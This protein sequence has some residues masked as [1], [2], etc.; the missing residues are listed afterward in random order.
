MRVTLFT[1]YICLVFQFCCYVAFAKSLLNVVILSQ[2]IPL[3]EKPALALESAFNSAFSDLSDVKVQLLHRDFPSV[4]GGWTIWPLIPRLGTDFDWYLFVEPFTEV[5][6]DQLVEFLKTQNSEESLFFGHGL[7]DSHPVIIHHFRGFDGVEQLVYPDFGAGVVFSRD[8]I[9]KLKSKLAEDYPGNTFA[10]DPKHELAKLVDDL[11]VT[12]LTTNVGFCLQQTASNCFTHYAPPYLAPNSTTC[13]RGITNRHVFVGVKTFSG[14][15]KT[16]VVVVKRTWVKEVKFV[17]F[18]SDT[19]DFYIPAIDIGVPNTERGHCS[20]T[21][22]ILK[23][24][25]EHTDQSAD[26]GWII[27]ADDDTLLSIPRLYRLL[28]CLPKQRKLI[29]GERY[30][31]GFSTDGLGGYDY[32]TGGAGMIFSRAAA[33]QIVASCQCPNDDSPDDMILGAC[34]RRLAIPVIH[35][36]AFHQAQPDDYAADYLQRQAPISFHKFEHIDPYEVYMNYLYEKDE[37]LEAEK[38]STWNSQ[39]ANDL[40]NQHGHNEL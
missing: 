4:T 12:K 32:P 1:L 17:E 20:K 13:G 34:A 36:S 38:K 23:H 10:I 30:G 39:H 29:L 40:H 18:F 25:L 28:N 15:H 21:L 8:L 7:V 16:R 33:R 5:N 35:S 19:P 11:T 26:I 2:D 3:E 24:A 14:N 22:A 9:D 31:Y 37:I 6:V 27:I